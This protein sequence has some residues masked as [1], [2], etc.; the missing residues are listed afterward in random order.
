MQFFRHA[1]LIVS[2]ALAGL[3]MEGSAQGVDQSVYY[4]N[5]VWYSSGNPAMETQATA[6]FTAYLNG[7]ESRILIENAPRWEEGGDPNIDGGG[8]FGVD[9]ANFPTLTV[10][11]TVYVRYTSLAAGERGMLSEKVTAIPWTRLPQTL[12]LEP[13]TIPDAPQDVALSRSEGGVRHVTWTPVDGHTYI[14][15]RRTVQDTIPS[16]RSRNLYTRVA[17]GIVGG[18][19]EDVTADPTL[20]Y[21]YIVYAV[22][23]DGAVSVH[24]QEARI[25]EIIEGLSAEAG[26]RNVTLSWSPF[27][28]SIGQIQ[29]Y[30]IYRRTADGAFG[31]PIAFTGRDTTYTDTRLEPESPYYYTVRGRVDDGTE[32][33]SAEEVGVETGMPTIDIYTYASLKTAVVVYHDTNLGQIPEERLEDF[34]QMLEEART[35]FWRNSGMKLNLEFTYYPITERKTFASREDYAVGA[36]AQ[37]LAELGVMNTQYD[38]V[39]RI[40]PATGGYW[41][42][43]IL[44]LDLPGPARPTGFSQT[45]WPYGTGVIYPGHEE[46]LDYGLTWIFTHEIQH[47]IDAVYNENGHPELAHGDIPWVFNVP[48]GEHFD[49]QAKALRTFTAYE[50]LEPA[51]GDL[52]ETLDLDGDGFPDEDPRAPLDEARFGSS[53]ELVD[54]DGDGLSD[55]LEAIDGSYGGSDPLDTDT[56]DDGILDGSDEH[57]RYPVKTTIHKFTPV[58]DGEI[59]EGWPLANDSVSYTQV[60]YAPELFLSYDADSLYLG[61][62]LP[63]IGIPE[64]WLDFGADGFWHGRGNTMMTFNLSEGTFN[65][66]RTRD[67]SPEA[68]ELNEAGLWDDEAGYE[69]R[70]GRRVFTKGAVNLGIGIDWPVIQLEIAIP[71]RDDAGLTLQEGDSLGLY[72]NYSK[73]NN[74]PSEWATT[75]DQYSFVTFYVGD[76]SVA[77]ESGELPRKVELLQNYPNP[78]NPSTTISYKLARQGPVALRVYDVL[79]REV[80]TLVDAVQSAGSYEVRLDAADLPS[81]MYLYRLETSEATV[82]RSMLLVR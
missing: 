68:R 43:G 14:V 80:R 70:F 29:G 31:A 61:L 53:S 59:E 56:D 58:I 2:F 5:F 28:P 62:R 18:E 66:L 67:A 7:D 45:E 69:D 54:T 27:T 74:Q 77:T 46:G 32:L 25:P 15:Y 9:L 36:T 51:W 33:G 39:F 49:F 75:F 38:L 52:Y 10:G 55:R 19:Y 26:T 47:A 63:E 81:G 37:H 57:P 42:F 34:Q 79:G 48:A 21:G 71:R 73:V 16:G 11:D 23:E 13:A 3:P 12:H 65:Q 35:F 72:V 82:S 78:F 64:I 1:V 6:S 30:N 17:D 22:S 44:P 8:T 4:R 24:S 41:S 60:G 50:D 76:R 20:A 40:T